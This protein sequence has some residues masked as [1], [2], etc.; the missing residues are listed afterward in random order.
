[1]KKLEANMPN[2][3]DFAAILEQVM[4]KIGST[5]GDEEEETPPKKTKFTENREG[6]GDDDRKLWRL[7]RQK[8]MLMIKLDDCCSK[9]L[10]ES[11]GNIEE[12]NNGGCRISLDLCPGC[13]ELNLAVDDLTK[14][15][16]TSEK[17]KGKKGNGKENWN[18]N[19]KRNY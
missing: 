17:F 18:G 13:V 9:R 10:F 3:Q 12:D 7:V 16:T 14:S 4:K 19:R 6:G 11:R 2:Q 1:L 8:R 5:E 15:N